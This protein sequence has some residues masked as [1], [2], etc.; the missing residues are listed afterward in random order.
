VFVS[1]EWTFP[2]LSLI[3]LFLNFLSCSFFPVLRNCFTA[4][5]YLPITEAVL[6]SLTSIETS[7]PFSLIFITRRILSNFFAVQ[8]L[9]FFL[10]AFVWFKTVFG[11]ML[12]HA[13]SFESDFLDFLASDKTERDCSLRCFCFGL[14]FDHLLL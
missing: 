5:W 11:E 8:R 6:E 12:C 3:F 13:E 1:N 9:P 10:N 4:L 7:L 2:L 14:R